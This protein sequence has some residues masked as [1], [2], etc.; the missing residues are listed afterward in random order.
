[1]SRNK[2]PSTMTAEERW[3]SWRDGRSGL[4]AYLRDFEFELKDALQERLLAIRYILGEDLLV[5]I[6]SQSMAENITSFT[7]DQF[8]STSPIAEEWEAAIMLDHA[9]LYGLYGV[10]PPNKVSSEK[11]A[12]VATLP[13]RLDEWR[14]FVQPKKDGRIE[15]II[16]LALSRHT[17]DSGMSLA[18]LT[19]EDDVVEGEVDLRS[20]S[21]FGGVGEAHIR[22]ILS[23]GDSCLVKTGQAVTASS[24]AQWLKGRKDFCPS[25]WQNQKLEPLAPNPDFEGE[26]IF[27]PVAA[28]GTYFQPGLARNGRFSVGAVGKEARYNSFNDALAALHKMAIPR[29]RRPNSEGNWGL[30]AGVEWKRVERAKL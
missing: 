26:V 20:L 21:T 25:I 13:V 22:N 15:Q 5:S 30:V 2:A 11:S 29:W 14:Q 17:M 16:N 1:M 27:V 19:S 6:Q 9:G 4:V 8:L 18:S 10:V 7:F 23:Q 12:W 28:D 24:A 3:S